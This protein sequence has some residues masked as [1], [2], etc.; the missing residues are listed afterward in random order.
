MGDNVRWAGLWTLHGSLHG[1]GFGSLPGYETI[2]LGGV[3]ML[4]NGAISWHSRMQEVTAPGTSEAEYVAL[5]EVVK[6]VLF[7]RQVQ[8]FMRPSMRVSAVNV[9][10]DNEGAIELATN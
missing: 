1:L 5:S 8:E 10:E 2:G 7:L 3:L 9:F 6:E 4:A